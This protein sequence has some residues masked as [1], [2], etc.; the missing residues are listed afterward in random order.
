[1]GPCRCRAPKMGATSEPCCPPSAVT[2]DST[3]LPRGRIPPESKNKGNEA[4]VDQLPSGPAQPARVSCVLDDVIL[5]SVGMAG[6]S[7]TS[8]AM[9]VQ[10]RRL[11]FLD[12]IRIHVQIQ[13]PALSH[14]WF[15]IRIWPHNI[16]RTHT[17]AGYH[18][19]RPSSFHYHY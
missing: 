10:I 3:I 18:V 5:R 8:S 1:M 13:R 15:R 17:P 7:I 19:L 14:G 2:H 9:H 16:Y 6:I 11:Y 4:H 12:C